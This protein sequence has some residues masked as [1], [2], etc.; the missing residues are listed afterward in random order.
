MTLKEEPT[1]MRYEKLPILLRYH[2]Q[3]SQDVHCYWRLNKLSHFKIISGQVKINLFMPNSPGAQHWLWIKLIFPISTAKDNRSLALFILN[4]NFLGSLLYLSPFYIASFL[5]S[6]TSTHF[7]QKY[8]G[9]N[10]NFYAYSKQVSVSQIHQ[11]SGPE[12]RK[13]HFWYTVSLLPTPTSTHTQTHT[14]TH[15]ISAI[16]SPTTHKNT[17]SH[18]MQ[19]WP[20]VLFSFGHVILKHSVYVNKLYF[21]NVFNSI[22][23]K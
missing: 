6:Y 13:G 22:F 10:Y 4:P 20:T 1:K 17:H 21:L 19:A 8:F 16:P 3:I 11:F 2:K 15:S 12:L 5:V 18:K 9:F 14:H 23:F 7:L